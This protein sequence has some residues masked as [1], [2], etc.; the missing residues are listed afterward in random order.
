MTLKPI[1][2][3]FIL[4]YGF[5][6]PVRYF[7]EE[8]Q[9]FR[10]YY[11]IEG[12]SSPILISPVPRI[13]RNI[14]IEKQIDSFSDINTIEKN[15]DEHWNI[16]VKSLD[17]HLTTFHYQEELSNLMMICGK[18]LKKNGFE[19]GIYNHKTLKEVERLVEEQLESNPDLF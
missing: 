1:N 2:K 14:S 19:L 9:Q 10:V 15:S 12:Y 8:M 4:R 16:F 7:D 17:N 11:E 5:S 3:E 13:Y 6:D 18:P